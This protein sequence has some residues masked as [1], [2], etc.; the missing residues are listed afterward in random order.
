MLPDSVGPSHE[1]SLDRQCGAELAAQDLQ[2]GG[3]DCIACNRL[4]DLNGLFVVPLRNR[5]AKKHFQTV[6]EL[7]WRTER[8][9][10][11]GRF[12][13]IN[14]P[15]PWHHSIHLIK[16]VVL[17]VLRTDREKPKEGRILLD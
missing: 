9:P 10:I 7:H 5:D 14:P 15:C 12:N 13:Q 3:S 2:A 4:H 16:K 1:S 11:R 17:P 8:Y 6:F